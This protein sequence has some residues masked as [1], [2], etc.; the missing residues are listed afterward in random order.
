[1]VDRG[2]RET[3]YQ[4]LTLEVHRLRLAFPAQP[5]VAVVMA[6][7]I[8]I[9]P[10]C[11]QSE[12]E[13]E[14][15]YKGKTLRIMTSNSPGGGFDFYMRLTAKYVGEVTGVA[16]AAQNVEGAGGTLGD[17]KLYYSRADGLT[18]G[19][20]NS[21]G[22]IFA[23][24]RGHPGVQYDFRKWKWL[25]R[26]A[27]IPPAI[28]VAPNSPYQTIADLIGTE[29]EIRF[30]L[31]GRGS[32]AYYGTV[33]LSNVLGVPVKQIVGYSGPGEIA[34]AMLAGEIDARF[35]SI[36]TLLP[37]IEQGELRLLLIFD[38]EPDVRFPEIPTVS[39]LTVE[40]DVK[41]KLQAYAAVYELERSFVAPPDTP[42]KRVDYL[43]ALLWRAWNT[44]GFQQELK[45]AGRGFQ[46]MAGSDLEREAAKVAE[47]LDALARLL[48]EPSS[49]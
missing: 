48:E 13:D 11:R 2:L 40:E 45:T 20:I 9:L 18:I 36:D 5:L 30:G 42:E 19:L 38:T 29:Q 41:K 16:V 24:L 35:E 37:L 33:F 7:S 34:G 49:Q 27:G 8:L 23:Q 44:D 25:G 4:L 39:D 28:A 26:V 12:L 17:N 46:L 47:Q 43:R 22:H 31:E 1:M 10:A 32:D 21:P 6:V 3:G 14:D 15:F